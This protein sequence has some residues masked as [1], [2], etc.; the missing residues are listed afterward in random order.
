[1]KKENQELKGVVAAR[2]ARIRQ[3]EAQLAGLST[4]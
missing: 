2:D 4:N 3:L 1:L